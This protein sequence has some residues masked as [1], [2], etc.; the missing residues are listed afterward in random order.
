MHLFNLMVGNQVPPSILSAKRPASHQR[1]RTSRTHS[2]L[3]SL[4]MC[5]ASLVFPT[6]LLHLPVMPN[7]SFG[8]LHADSNS[9]IKNH[10]I[11]R[12]EWYDRQ[13]N[14][15]EK[16]LLNKVSVLVG[17]S[18][19]KLNPVATMDHESQLFVD[20]P[21]FS[22]PNSQ[23]AAS[24]DLSELKVALRRHSISKSHWN[25][26]VFEGCSQALDV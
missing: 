12:S 23:A 2:C 5:V 11:T 13:C 18:W 25:D 7:E 10:N 26:T 1:S 16:E 15:D 20:L 6:S 24:S 14:W 19:T 4:G 22:A 9:P 21:R 8:Q 17:N 3:Q